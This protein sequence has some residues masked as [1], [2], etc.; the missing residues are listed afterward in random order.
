VKIEQS[1]HTDATIWMVSREYDGLAGAGGVKDVCRQLAEFLAGEGGYPVRV[2]L[3]RYGFMDPEQFG[4]SPLTISGTKAGVICGRQFESCFAV[5]MDYPEQERREMV[6]IWSQVI[7]GVSVYLVE[8]DRFGGKQGVYT[9]TSEEEQGLSWQK[10]GSGHYDYFAM[11][12]LLQKAS[13][14]MMILCKD[15]PWVVH[16]QDGHAAILPAMMR[17]NSGY[18]N[19]FR[20]TGAVVTVHNAGIG[21]HQEIEDLDFARA[22]TGLPENIIL[23]NLLGKSFDPFLAAA[24]Y[25]VLNTVSENYG[26]ELQETAEDARTGWLGHALKAR[27]VELRGVTNGIDPATFDPVNPQKLGLAAPFNVLRGKLEG[28]LECKNDLLSQTGRLRQWEYVEQFGH[29]APASAVPL[30]TFIGRLAGQKG[31]DIVLDCIPW[32]FAKREEAQLL[33]L[34]SGESQVEDALQSLAERSGVTGRFCFLKGFDSA[35]ANK[36]YAAG[37]FFLIPSLYEPCGL[38]DYIAQLL[39]NLPIVHHVGGLVKVLDGETGFAYQENS[40]QGL[41]S[42]MERALALYEQPEK[43][44][45]MQQAA[46]K[47]IFACHTWQ[48]VMSEY[49]LLY[50]QA[51]GLTVGTAQ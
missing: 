14:E 17:E 11:N 42:T 43:H 33:I 6:A 46:V 38:T 16:C 36:V 15:A 47:N 21:Y 34:G 23:K 12:I 4:F 10:Q 32:F 48:D 50:E 28:K 2:M 8:A 3:P 19:F 40:S 27:K 13:L 26:R 51:Q 9:Y 29:L 24:D 30:F 41:I 49:I 20:H 22:V 37:D 35:L 31:I 39:G 25:A 44:L 7:N 18:R 5:D 45:R 1:I